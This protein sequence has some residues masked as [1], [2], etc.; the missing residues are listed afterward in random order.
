MRDS[1]AGTKPGAVEFPRRLTSGGNLTTKVYVTTIAGS[2]KSSAFRKS[3]EAVRAICVVKAT[4]TSIF[5][6]R[7]S[8]RAS[9]QPSVAPLRVFVAVTLP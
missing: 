7:A 1:S 3:A 5:G 2:V 6:W 8:T 9:Q 4:A